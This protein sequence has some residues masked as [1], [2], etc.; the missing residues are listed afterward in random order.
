MGKIDKWMMLAIGLV[1]GWV[2][3]TAP[4]WLHASS[5]EHWWDIAI[6]VGTI[7]TALAALLLG[8]REIRI[9]SKEKKEAS[10]HSAVLLWPVLR[11]YLAAINV[12]QKSHYLD[13]DNQL[14]LDVGK[15]MRALEEIESNRER[16]EILVSGLAIS[17]KRHALYV[18]ANLAHAKR[19]I[20]DL[21][22][23]RGEVSKNRIDTKHKAAQDA[24][25]RSR[26]RLHYLTVH[27][28]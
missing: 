22:T 25:H 23:D 3:S 19:H 6:A 27:C 13:I 20:S 11:N 14:S 7:G 1:G 2:I 26:G 9:R 16:A 28:K 12:L 17:Q 21:V 15:T 10:A 18:L 8:V 24:L 5:Y 4:G